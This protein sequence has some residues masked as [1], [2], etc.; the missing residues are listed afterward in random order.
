M[1][2]YHFLTEAEILAELEAS[3]YN[4]MTPAEIEAEIERLQQAD[5][6][7][8]P[9]TILPIIQGL[10]R[11]LMLKKGFDLLKKPNKQPKKPEKK[12]PK[13]DVGMPDLDGTLGYE[14]DPDAGPNAAEWYR[15]GRIVK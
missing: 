5:Q 1:R 13:R 11:L 4:D 15:K 14:M 10:K 8:E 7:L 9:V 6:P 3:S 12:Q 2:D